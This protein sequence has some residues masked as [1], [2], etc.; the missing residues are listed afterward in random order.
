MSGGAS[1]SLCW[2]AQIM[3][4]IISL[5]TPALNDPMIRFH[6]PLLTPIAFQFQTFAPLPESA[7][8]CSNRAGNS[9]LR[10]IGNERKMEGSV[11]ANLRPSGEVAAMQGGERH[12]YSQPTIK[13]GFSISYIF[14][15]PELIRPLLMSGAEQ[16][17]HAIPLN[18]S[19]CGSQYKNRCSEGVRAVEAEAVRE[20]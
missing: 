15:G 18:T 6:R 7:S 20:K 14:T 8:P 1:G 5:R 2:T 4:K 10:S 3:P 17:G 16:L 13:N 11:D 12:T 19:G 9:S